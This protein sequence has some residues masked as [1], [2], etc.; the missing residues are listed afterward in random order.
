VYEGLGELLYEA[1]E[2]GG[3]PDL[4]HLLRTDPGGDGGGGGREDGAG[5][6]EEEAGESVR[7]RR[8]RV[9]ERIIAAMERNSEG[10]AGAG[11]G[12]YHNSH[13]RNK[14]VGW[15]SLI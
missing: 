2:A 5:D 11:E 7:A 8:A 3:P 4:R 12:S 13:R 9:G 1:A 15:G 10:A 6:D 14:E